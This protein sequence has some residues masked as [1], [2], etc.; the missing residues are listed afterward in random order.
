VGLSPD[1]VGLVDGRQALTSA[2]R[3]SARGLGDGFL[4]VV[5]NLEGVVGLELGRIAG[6]GSVRAEV[7][8]PDCRRLALGILVD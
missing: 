5:V 6:Y 4:G 2:A 1:F 7:L 8:G 3:F